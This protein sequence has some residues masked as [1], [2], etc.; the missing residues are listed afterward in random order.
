MS[1]ARNGNR[2]ID[3]AMAKI[4][5]VAGEGHPLLAYATVIGTTRGL[6]TLWRG[7]NTDMANMAR[8]ML[9]QLAEGPK[10]CCCTSCDA[11]VDA[12]KAAMDVFDLW[13]EKHGT[14]EPLH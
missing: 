6:R 8:C 3:K 5:A 9:R 2:V 11:A 10:H 7:N 1:N 13:M 12:A 4:C 14:G